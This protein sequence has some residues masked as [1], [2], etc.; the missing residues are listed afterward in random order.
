VEEYLG[1]EPREAGGR[2]AFVNLSDTTLH[3]VVFCC[4][5]LVE[6]NVWHASRFALAGM[7]RV[8]VVACEV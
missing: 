8:G 5:A 1:I 7:A 6:N 2:T 4:W 3:C